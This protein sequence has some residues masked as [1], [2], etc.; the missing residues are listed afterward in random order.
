MTCSEHDNRLQ[1]GLW[2]CRECHQLVRV[3]LRPVYGVHGPPFTKASGCQCNNGDTRSRLDQDCCTDGNYEY[4]VCLRCDMTSPHELTVTAVSDLHRDHAST[5][6]PDLC[7]VPV[8]AE[9]AEL[10]KPVLHSVCGVH[11]EGDA[12]VQVQQQG[13]KGLADGERAHAV[14]DAE[15]L[16][17]ANCRQV[18]GTLRLCCSGELHAL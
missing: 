13:V 8:I 4:N 11:V 17:T 9:V 7:N 16:R 6:H 2:H 14:L 15:G 18:E 1:R 12:A 10:L 3:H 5:L